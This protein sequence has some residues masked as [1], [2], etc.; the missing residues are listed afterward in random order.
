MSLSH[1]LKILAKGIHPETGEYL[2]EDSVVNSVESVRLLFAL[3]EELETDKLYK[4]DKRKSKLTPE[5]R[6]AKNVAEN[7]PANAGF[8]WKDEDKQAL[9]KHYADLNSIELLSKRFERSPL[10]IAIQLEKLN[11]IPKDE[12]ENYRSN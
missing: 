11:L 2:D 9:I 8:P 5:E 10:S 1:Q 6:R 4:S 12:V 3:A 7:K